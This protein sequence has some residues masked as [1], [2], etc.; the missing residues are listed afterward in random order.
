VYSLNPRGA[1]ILDHEGNRLGIWYSS[2][3]QTLVKQE[4]DGRIVVVTPE[5]PDLRGVR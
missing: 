2:Q 1:W 3:Y 5:P 4:K